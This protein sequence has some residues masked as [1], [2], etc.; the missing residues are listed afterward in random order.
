VKYQE[1]SLRLNAFLKLVHE[2]VTR[3]KF[4]NSEKRRDNALQLTLNVIGIQMGQRV[5]HHDSILQKS[6][7]DF[8]L[9]GSARIFI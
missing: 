8:S 1:V 6:M 2:R 4:G 3:K 5:F 7:G 9:Q